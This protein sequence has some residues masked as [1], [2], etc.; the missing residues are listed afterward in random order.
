MTG[1]VDA[2]GIFEIECLN[3]RGQYER[4]GQCKRRTYEIE[5]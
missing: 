2:I 5:I 1:R 3:K 4:E